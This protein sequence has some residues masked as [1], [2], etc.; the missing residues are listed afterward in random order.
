M[1]DGIS[2]VHHARKEEERPNKL[3]TTA[4]IIRIAKMPWL[5]YNYVGLIMSPFPDEPSCVQRVGNITNLPSEL[6]HWR[7]AHDLNTGLNLSS[8]VTFT[9]DCPLIRAAPSAGY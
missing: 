2:V 3:A 4:S 5:N 8:F 9:V 6:V 1:P 7:A